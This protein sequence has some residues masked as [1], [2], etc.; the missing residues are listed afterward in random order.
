MLEVVWNGCDRIRGFDG[1]WTWSG[2]VAG[3]V[4]IIDRAVKLSEDCECYAKHCERGWNTC[5]REETRL[6]ILTRLHAE[7]DKVLLSF[8]FLKSTMM[9]DAVTCSQFRSEALSTS[10]ECT[11]SQTAALTTRTLQ[12]KHVS[13]E[14]VFWAWICSLEWPP[15]QLSSSR[16]WS[17]AAAWVCGLRTGVH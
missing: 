17:T 3:R 4:L 9:L 5:Q 10:N 12:T 15:V 14:P 16:L 11:T 6:R 13:P 1:T 8:S 2:E 7:M